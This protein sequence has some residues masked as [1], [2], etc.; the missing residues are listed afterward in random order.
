MRA[1]IRQGEFI[2]E[3]SDAILTVFFQFALYNP[4]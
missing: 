4:C 3:G 2:R 1:S